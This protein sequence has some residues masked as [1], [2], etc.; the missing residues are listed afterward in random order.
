MVAIP[1]APKILLSKLP[2]AVLSRCHTRI[3]LVITATLEVH[4]QEAFTLRDFLNKPWSL[5]FSLVL[6]G[7][8][9][10][11]FVAHKSSIPKLHVEFHLLFFCLDRTMV[12]INVTRVTIT[13][14]SK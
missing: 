11:F 9:L 5:V 4:S 2:A 14:E 10:L 1:W 7:T 13:G 8:C 6:L 12:S 3:V